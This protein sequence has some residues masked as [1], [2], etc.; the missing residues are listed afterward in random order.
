MSP[1]F[2]AAVTFTF[3]KF[4][5]TDFVII[6][7][8]VWK[9]FLSFLP[10]IQEDGSQRRVNTGGVCGREGTAIA[11]KTN[12]LSSPSLLIHQKARHKIAPSIDKNVALVRRQGNQALPTSCEEV[13]CIES[14][15]S[16][17]RISCC[18]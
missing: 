10:L 16:C 11:N 1:F 4:F 18:E 3:T 14:T 13:R 9:F 17:I 6:F 5:Q 15:Q 12:R 2:L 7:D 8:C